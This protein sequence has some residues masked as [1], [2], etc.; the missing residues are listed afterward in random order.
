LVVRVERSWSGPHRVVFQ[1]SDKFYDL[2]CQHAYDV[3]LQL[4][5]L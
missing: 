5:N 2:D 4:R 3:W 1:G